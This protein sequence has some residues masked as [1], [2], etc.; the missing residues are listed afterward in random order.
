MVLYSNE[1]LLFRKMYLHG[2]VYLKACLECISNK[3]RQLNVMIQARI[4]PCLKKLGIL[5]GY[6][7]E[8]EAW[9][10][11]INEKYTAF[12]IYNNRF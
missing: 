7:N 12:L 5:L 4:Q 2:V 6:Y 9:P 1:S 11:D 3:K 8:K 10:R